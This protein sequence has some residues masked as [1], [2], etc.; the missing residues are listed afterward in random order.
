MDK[1]CVFGHKKAPEIPKM[2]G[3]KDVVT[4]SN[5]PSEDGMQQ[6]TSPHREMSSPTWDPSS[7]HTA[8]PSSTVWEASNCS[9]DLHESSPVWRRSSPSNETR[10]QGAIS[11]IELP[12][13]DDRY[14]TE[15][16]LSTQTYTAPRFFPLL[17]ILRD[18]L[19]EGNGT[20]LRSRVGERLGGEGT[21]IYRLSGVTNFKAYVELAARAGLIDLI[22]PTDGP[23][24]ERISLREV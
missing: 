11:P 17:K 1:N 19:R 15:V 23:G 18:F 9:D 22:P 5:L 2:S 10:L 3:N 13:T 6:P 12:D 16:S 14:E 21:K 20:P 4:Y 7:Y 8:G 24:T